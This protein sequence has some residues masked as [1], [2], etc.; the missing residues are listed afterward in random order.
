[1]TLRTQLGAWT[2]TEAAEQ[3]ART[4]VV[5][6]IGA[7]E[8]HGPHLPLATDTL[9]AQYVAQAAVDS[10]AD[11]VP[12]V[13]APSIPYGYSQHHMPFGGTAS[14]GIEQLL[15]ALRGIVGS[16]LDSGFG[17]VFVLNGH[18]GNQEIV[19]LIARDVGL[20]H[21]A[22]VGAGSY[23]EMARPALVAAGAQA[24]GEIPG[25]AGVFETSLM[26]AAH[27]DLVQLSEAPRRAQ[28]ETGWP[29]PRP[30]R[31]SPP[32]PFRGKDGF[33]DDPGAADAEWGAR[34]LNL[35]ATAVGEAL[36]GFHQQRRQHD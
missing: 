16:L 8:Q 18:G 1:M 29:E 33:S 5:L 36:I 15:G 12:A 22:Y 30:Y 4:M 20:S 13:V 10:V 21:D 24:L 31:A 3:A 32:G 25:H 28:P 7:L 6:P 11:R 2:R 35:C 26:L 23:F 19:S 17:A 34:A 27:P 9:L 14:M